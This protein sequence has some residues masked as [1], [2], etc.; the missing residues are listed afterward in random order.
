LIY[1]QYTSPGTSLYRDKFPETLEEARKFFCD[2][3]YESLIK[4]SLKKEDWFPCF[5][6]AGTGYNGTWLICKKC[7]GK[8]SCTKKVFMDGWAKEKK[9]YEKA[10]EEYN[11]KY[12]VL[13]N[14]FRRMT[15]EEVSIL[16]EYMDPDGCCGE[17]HNPE[18]YK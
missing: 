2:P 13:K 4:A 6:C 18:W 12:E 1:L 16:D 7:D 3:H 5:S 15:D 9:K 8:R 10:V 14:L 17:H 11:H